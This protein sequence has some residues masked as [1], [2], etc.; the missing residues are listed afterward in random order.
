MLSLSRLTF[1]YINWHR[2][3]SLRLRLFGLKI[4]PPWLNTRSTGALEAGAV[5]TSLASFARA[6]NSE[7]TLLQNLKILISSISSSLVILRTPWSYS[8]YVWS[9]LCTDLIC[10]VE[11]LLPLTCELLC[12]RK[13][14]LLTEFDANFRFLADLSSTST[15]STSGFSSDKI[16]K[17]LIYTSQRL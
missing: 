1:R 2:L 6:G 10:D 5:S 14:R 12:L 3:L 11:L 17:V 16:N 15:T 13:Y 9:Y 4:C 7:L 8:R